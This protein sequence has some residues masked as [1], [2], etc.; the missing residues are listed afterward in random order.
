M[1]AL[2][3]VLFST[4]AAIGYGILHDRVT[5]HVCVEYFTIAHPPVFPTESPFLLAIGWGVIATW[6]VG[7]PLGVLLAAAA[8]IGSQPKLRLADLRRPILWL[9]AASGIAALVSGSTGATLVGMG[10]LPAPGDWAEAIPPEKHVAF[11]FDAWA[12]SASYLSGAVGGLFLI[13]RTAW[14]RGRSVEPA[15]AVE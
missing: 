9:M 12:H 5:A 11:S 7:L 1:E 10:A 15:T 2:K 14:L 13:V 3:I 4:I 6:W 8:R